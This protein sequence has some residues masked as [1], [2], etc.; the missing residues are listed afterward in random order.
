[1]RDQRWYRMYEAV[2]VELHAPRLNERLDAVD[3]AI[4]ERLAELEPSCETD[5]ELRILADAEAALDVL[6]H[7]LKRRSHSSRQDFP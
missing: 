5:K 7:R 1:M 6:R 4:R 3:L 2:L